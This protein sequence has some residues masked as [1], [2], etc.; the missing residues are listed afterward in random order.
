VYFRIA[1]TRRQLTLKESRREA[2][3]QT[4]DSADHVYPCHDEG[5]SEQ[6]WLLCCE[7]IDQ[8][9]DRNED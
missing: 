2:I 3:P 4:G 1:A 6:G 8:T 7:E 9:I 5:G